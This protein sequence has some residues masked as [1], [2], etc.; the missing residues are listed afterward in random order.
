MRYRDVMREQQISESIYLLLLQKKE[1]NEIILASNQGNIR[2]IDYAYSNGV[3][4]FPKKKVIY[5]IAFLLG[6]ILPGLFI[7]IRFLLDNKF[8]NVHDLEKLGLPTIG[9]IPQSKVK[10]DIFDQKSPHSPSA[11]AFRLLRSNIN[12]MLNPHVKSNVIMVTSTIAGEGKTYVSLKLANTLANTMK[13]VVVVGMD[14][15]APKLMEYMGVDYSIGVSNYLV[16]PE[17][18]VDDIKIESPH[19][20]LITFIPS[21]TIP[22]N[23]N[24][25]L[26][27]PRVAELFEKLREEYDYVIVD[28]SP[29][30]L[31]AD[32]LSITKH[33]DLMLYVSR[34]NYID[35]RKLTIPQKL[36]KENKFNSVIWLAN[37][38][39]M[40]DN[41]YGY[42]YGYGSAERNGGIKGK[43]QKIFRKN[44]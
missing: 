28:T 32:T 24:E 41:N 13:K 7:F 15:R 22:P 42:G 16:K 23:P 2:V 4:V 1:E 14:L 12:F 11:E 30:G 43:I 6:I 31:V 5:F 21:G 25:I 19:N 17:I 36:Y 26:L 20:N 27:R 9:E 35:K 38:I 8:R 44:G 18:T 34:A 37:G 29:V 10:D 3:P 39:D 40:K 33:A